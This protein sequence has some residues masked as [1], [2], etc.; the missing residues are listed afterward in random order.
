MK[1]T[2]SHLGRIGHAEIDLAPF[3]VFVGPNSTNKT[4][5]TY[6][7]FALLEGCRGEDQWL[8]PAFTRDP[9]V[10]DAVNT[11][12]KR[13]RDRAFVHSC[14]SQQSARLFWSVDEPPTHL[15]CT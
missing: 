3:T 11:T 5:V 2:V 13:L 9:A 14:L 4:W 7:L 8:N 12:V 15:Q 1:L 10:I 6:S